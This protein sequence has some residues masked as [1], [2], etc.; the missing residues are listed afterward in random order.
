MGVLFPQRASW[1]T[2]L[3]ALVSMIACTHDG[4]LR[5]MLANPKP[6][7]SLA[8]KNFYADLCSLTNKWQGWWFHAFEEANLPFFSVLDSLKVFELVLCKWWSA[9]IWWIIKLLPIALCVSSSAQSSFTVGFCRTWNNIGEGNITCTIWVVSVWLQR[10]DS[11]YVF[12]SV[13]ACRNWISFYIFFIHLLLSVFSQRLDSSLV[14][15]D[16]FVCIC[17]ACKDWILVPKC[18]SSLAPLHPHNHLHAQKIS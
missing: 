7:T 4:H 13:F 16:A 11:Y 6:E 18:G 3:L 8:T 1:L 9:T 5:C 12:A 14:L 2:V 17:F 15:L 10:L